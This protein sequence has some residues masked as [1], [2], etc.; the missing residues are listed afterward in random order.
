[1]F[2]SMKKKLNYLSIILLIIVGSG[3]ESDNSCYQGRVVS[4]SNGACYS[5]IKIEKSIPD[6]I[7]VNSTISFDPNSTSKELKINGTVNFIILECEKWTGISNTLCL[8]PQ[9]TG[10]IEFCNK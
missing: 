5:I 6:G 4:L 2:N 1:M 9:Y 8:S 10:I 3:C 7:S